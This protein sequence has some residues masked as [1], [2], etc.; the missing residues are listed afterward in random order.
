VTIPGDIRS[1]GNIN[2]DI[3]LDDSTKRIWQFGEDGALTF[4]DGTSQ[5]TAFNTTQGTIDS[6]SAHNIN[7]VDNTLLYIGSTTTTIAV[8][9][10]NAGSIVELKG[11]T[12]IVN[13]SN[14]LNYI[15]TTSIGASGNYAGQISFNGNYIYYCTAN[16]D[17]VSNIWV[18]VAWSGSTW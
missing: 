17:G 5:S 6:F 11:Q 3:N 13:P 10:G 7:D 4:P 14:S 18:R 1:E 16:Y 15:P 12:L 9:R 2:I 8:G